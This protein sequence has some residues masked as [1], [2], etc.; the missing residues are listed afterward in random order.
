MA[1]KK[2]EVKLFA[3]VGRAANSWD[4]APYMSGA[5][6]DA[7]ISEAESDSATTSIDFIV[8][9]GGGDVKDAYIAIA[10]LER[11]TKPTRAVIA[12]YAASAGLYICYGC[13]E[14]FATKNAVIMPHGI[15]S[16]VSGS[17]QDMQ[18]QIDVMATYNKSLATLLVARTGLTEAE[19]TDKFLS[20]D[21]FMTAQEAL[22]NKLIDG[23]IDEDAEF[24][25]IAVTAGMPY[26]EFHASL[27]AK[28]SA[29]NADSFFDRI[30]AKVGS[31]FGL[32]PKKPVVAAVVELTDNEEYSISSM[33][34]NLSSANDSADYLND[35]TSNPELKAQ[36]KAILGFT[37]KAII[38]LTVM[39]YTEEAAD[40]TEAAA[41]VKEVSGKF[42]AKQTDKIMAGIKTDVEA[43]IASLTTPLKAQ[44]AEITTKYNAIKDLPGAKPSAVK[45]QK[46]A[47][48]VKGID[49]NPSLT[50][51]GKMKAKAADFS[52]ET[53]TIDKD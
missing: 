26:G 20:K 36:V 40:A 46:V 42:T 15:Q 27:H 29:G 3:F 14:V 9:S 24:D 34:Y 23:I 33:I 41:R 21:W 47:A 19:V 6:L 8:S 12:G 31:F 52:F 32:A 22:D 16:S 37:S 50:E 39:L 13:D 48:T 18:E 17:V 1:D 11:C 44:L 25:A 10:A 51:E 35:N 38:D 45:V 49:D 53:A 5:E 7:A 30:T 43:Q 4:K 28:L 2:S